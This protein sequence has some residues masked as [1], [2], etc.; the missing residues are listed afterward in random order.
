VGEALVGALLVLGAYAAGSVPWGVVL[1][2]RLAGVDVR[3]YGSGA[4]GATN[5]LRV[6]G[7]RISA[8]VFALD[9]LKGAV[10]VALGRALGVDWWAIGLAG[11]AAV[12]GHCWSP[13]IGF[14]GGKGMATGGGAAVAMF[15]WLVLVALP[16]LAVV[17]LTRY[18]SLA[19]LT[20]TATGP[21]IALT[22]AVLGLLAWQPALATTVIAGII[23]YKHRG[24]I[25]RLLA[26]TERRIGE[27]A[28]PVANRR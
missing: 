22:A 14:R 2:R 23:V 7:P 21:A 24:N 5:A 10:P 27:S 13:Y 12:A 17:A 19:S 6:L 20:A 11:I 18:V 8:A 26:R 28:N 15:P 3:S 1:G 9:F 25:E 16:M 4:T